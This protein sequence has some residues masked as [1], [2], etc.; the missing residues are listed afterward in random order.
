VLQSTQLAGGTAQRPAAGAAPIPTNVTIDLTEGFT[1]TDHLIWYFC[2]NLE[3]IENEEAT[4][5]YGYPVDRN[6]RARSTYF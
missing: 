2:F 1:G 5:R 3:L 4:S 6:V